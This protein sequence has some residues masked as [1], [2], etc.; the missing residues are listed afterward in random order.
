[1]APLSLWRGIL[2]GPQD[3]Q[4]WYVIFSFLL[5]LLLKRAEFNSIR[6]AFPLR[7]KA[8]KAAAAAFIIS[9]EFLFSRT[10]K[11][12]GASAMSCNVV[13]KQSVWQTKTNGAA[14]PVHF[15]T[16]FTNLLTVFDLD[17]DICSQWQNCENQHQIPSLFAALP[18]CPCTYPT[19][20][21]ANDE[22]TMS[23]TWDL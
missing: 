18:P 3:F 9:R 23:I 1:M 8:N 10:L 13:E 20:S 17:S 12:S 4:N 22:F 14:P 2:T 7:R 11:L 16:I 15:K 5:L 19:G 21:F 6:I